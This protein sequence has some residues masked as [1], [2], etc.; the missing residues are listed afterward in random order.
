MLMLM[1]V[2]MMMMMLNPVDG[3]GFDDG[4]DAG[5]DGDK[6]DVGVVVDG[7]DGH[8]MKTSA[9]HTLTHITPLLHPWQQHHHH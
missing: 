3:A 5:H 1:M 6:H 8:R 7:D 4:A 2:M 9:C